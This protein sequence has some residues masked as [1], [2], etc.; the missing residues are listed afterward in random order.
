MNSKIKVIFFDASNTL[1]FLVALGAW[2]TI[3]KSCF[4]KPYSTPLASLFS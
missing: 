3:T 4:I 1:L 2:A